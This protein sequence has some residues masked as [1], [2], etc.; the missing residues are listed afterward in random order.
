MPEMVAVV[1]MAAPMMVAVPAVMPVPVVAMPM[2]AAVP[3]GRLNERFASDWTA[4][5]GTLIGAAFAE[6]LNPVA[7]PSSASTTIR[8]LQDRIETSSPPC[9]TGED[10]APARAEPLRRA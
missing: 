5:I 6:R 9:D 3:A 4:A 1:V 10:R 7:P 2:P 8:N